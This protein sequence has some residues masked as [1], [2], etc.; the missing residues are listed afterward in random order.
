LKGTQ[1]IA[2]DRSAADKF[3]KYLLKSA[4]IFIFL[5]RIMIANIFAIKAKDAVPP[6]SRAKI[7]GK[8]SDSANNSD[9]SVVV[10]VSDKFLK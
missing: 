7:V 2:I 4:D 3:I 6:Y 10:F 5:T 1:N 8:G 9:N